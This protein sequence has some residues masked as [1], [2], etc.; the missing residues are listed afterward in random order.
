MHRWVGIAILSVSLVLPGILGAATR[1]GLHVS[2]GWLIIV[3]GLSLLACCW[4]FIAFW[5]CGQGFLDRPAPLQPSQQSGMPYAYF[6]TPCFQCLRF[7]TKGYAMVVSFMSALL[8]RCRPSCIFSTIMP[9]RIRIAINAMLT[10]GAWTQCGIKLCKRL[11]QTLDAS[12]SIFRIIRYIIRVFTTVFNAH[13]D[14]VFRGL[15]HTMCTIYSATC[16][17]AQTATTLYSLP[18]KMGLTTDFHRATSTLTDP[19]YMSIFSFWRW[20]NNAQIGKKFANHGQLS[21][22]N[23]IMLCGILISPSIFYMQSSHSATRLGLHVTS[24]ELAIWQSRMTNSTGTINGFNYQSIYQNR[25]LADANSFVGQSHPGGDGFWVGYTL[26]GCVPKDNQSINPGHGGTPFGRGNGAWMAR[27][28]FNFL[29]TGN[30]TYATPVRTEL[31]SQIAQA[32]TQWSN[33]TKWCSNNLGGGNALEIIPWLNRILI[34][35]DYLRAG[36]YTGFSA[37]EITSINTWFSDAAAL[38]K[39]VGEI[40]LGNSSYGDMF[41]VTPA[42]YACTG[43]CGGQSTQTLYF[44]G[45]VVQQATYFSFFNQP[46]NYALLAMQVGVMLDNSSYK[47]FARRYFTGYVTAGTWD[48]GAQ[49]GDW[50]RWVDCPACPQSMW[51]HATGALNGL[52]AIADVLA[53][54]GDTSLYDLTVNTQILGGGGSATSLKE[55]AQLLAAYAAKTLLH[56]GTTTSGDVGPATQLTWDNP[57]NGAGGDYHHFGLMVANLRYNDA[58]IT[59]GVTHNTLS[60]NTTSGCRDRQNGGCFSG[61]LAAW[62][63]LPFMFGNMQG[64]VNPFQVGSTAPTCTVTGPTS[65]PIHDTT[66][67][68]VTVSGTAA[69]ADGSVSSVAIGCSP[70]CG[71]PTVTGTTSWSASVPVSTGSNTVTATVTDNAA[72]T[73]TCQV[74]IRRQTAADATTGLRLHLPLDEGTG[75]TPQDATANNHDGVFSGTPT[76]V[77]GHIGPGAV[78]FD[79]GTDLIT[80]NGLLT[81]PTS[82]TLMSDF[83]LS[84]APSTYGD[85]ISIGDYLILRLFGGQLTGTFHNGASWVGL[86]TPW[87][88]DTAWHNLVFAYKSGEQT[89]YFDGQLVAVAFATGTPTYT[90]LGTNTILGMHGRGDTAFRF[91]GTLDNVKVWTRYLS[92]VD[93]A[94]ALVATPVPPTVVIEVPTSDPSWS[95]ASTPLTVSGTASD[96][97]GTV[98]TVVLTCSPSCGTPSNTGSATAW[99]FAVSLTVG[100]QVVTVV[101]TDNASQTSQDQLTV[102]YAP[103]TPVAPGPVFLMTG[104]SFY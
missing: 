26:A 103:A 62:A 47:E 1:L 70:S 86:S 84:T 55:T 68:A 30:T 71:T 43:P 66:A 25:I 63:D 33:S 48:N 53:R 50:Y 59:A 85:M 15:T 29:L 32:G 24:E 95:T 23:I 80:V 75:T 100:S 98:S 77:A 22:V 74:S 102:V 40:T 12:C 31:L 38:W 64:V 42:S 44:G 17:Y 35:Y 65:F 49:A 46:I 9:M 87:T 69:D 97:D 61:N 4:V 5:W 20:A 101:A 45:P 83:K 60:S 58:G 91:P 67:T 10:T 51:G 54:T 27:S 18:N 76:W 73:G 104:Q 8:F 81:S 41:D 14:C 28:A 92:G 93:V 16:R 88:A 36:G 3:Y 57:T 99:N 72:S 13:I 34:A 90:G 37:G 7:T 89:L 2:Q 94:A 6:F 82:A 21:H 96:P 11:P 39:Q 56:Y 78:L 19:L 52:I 79:A